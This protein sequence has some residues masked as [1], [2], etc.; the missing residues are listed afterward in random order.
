MKRILVPTDFSEEAENG[1]QTAMPIARAFEATIVLLH[2]LEVSGGD[3]L[4]TTGG[5]TYSDAVYIHEGLKLAQDN[6]N[7]SIILH[8]LDKGE[9]KLEKFIRIGTAAKQIE[10]SIEKLDIDFVVMG[11]RTAVDI[12]QLVLGTSTDKLIRKVNCPILSVNQVVSAHAFK[13]II[14]PT[15]TLS[16]ESGLI[17]IIKA[18]QEAFESKINMVLINTPLYFKSDKVSYKLLEKYAKA[19]GLKNYQCHV[20]SHTEEE[21]GILE[22]A[23]TMNESIIAVSTSAHTGLRKILQGSVTKELVGHAKRPVLTMKMDEA[24]R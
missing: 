20:Y 10:E 7:R 11:S 19:I 15:T 12:N 22:F 9:I 14:F 13:N 21:D 3:N 17:T 2:V 6:L 23:R 18:F 8:G 1:L 4:N 24:S 16:R 5:A